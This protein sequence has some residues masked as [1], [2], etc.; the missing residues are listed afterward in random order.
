MD[1]AANELNSVSIVDIESL[2][3]AWTQTKFNCLIMHMNI[4]S[5]SRNSSEFFT[6]MAALPR[7]PD[8]LVLSETWFS[9]DT[10]DDMDG[11]AGF[12]VYR[13]DRR[14]GGISIYIASKYK[15]RKIDRWSFIDEH[16]EVCSVELVL[17]EEAITVV[18]IYRPPDRNVQMFTEDIRGILGEISHRECT[19]IT[20]DL[21]IDLI[22]TN[23]VELE[24]INMCQTLSFEPLVDI[25]T[26]ESANSVSRCLDH[27]WFNQLRET[28]SGT[29]MVDITDH[30]PVYTLFV[31]RTSDRRQIHK[32][33]R[34]HGY[35]ALEDLRV[36]MEVYANE[37]S[38][39]D[40]T[41]V[42]AVVERFNSDFIKIYN[43]CCPLR[44]KFLTENRYLKPW[45]GNDLIICINRKH[46]LFRL[47]KR[48]EVDFN[49]YNTYKNRVTG[50]IKRAKCKY[51]NDKFN[52]SHGDARETWKRINSLIKS[53]PTKKT[54]D[55]IEIE[56]RIVNKLDEIAESFSCHFRDVASNLERNIPLRDGSPLDYMGNRVQRSMFVTPS[57]DSETANVICKLKNKS[58][59]LHCIPTFIY[60]YLS[61]LISPIVS[62]LF[63]L[64][65]IQGVFPSSLKIARITPIFKAGNARLVENYRPISTLPVLSKIFEK[66]MLKRLLLFINCNDLLG[67]NQ[68]GFRKNNNTSDAILEF[69]DSVYDSLSKR[70]TLIA[71]FLD[72]SKAFDTIHHDI[73]LDKLEYI[74][75][76]GQVRDWFRSYIGD[77]FQ[78]VSIGK[79]NST[80]VGVQRG[81]PQG[82]VLGPVLFILYI[83]DMQNCCSS[84]K[85]LHFADD[86]SGF[87]SSNDPVDL[88]EKVSRDL[89]EI[90]EWVCRNRLFLNI[91][92]TS[93]MV[94]SDRPSLDLPPLMIGTSILERVTH[95]RFLGVIIDER[96]SFKQHTDKLCKKLSQT[97][98]M[99]NRVSNLIPTSAKLN[100]YFSLIFSRVSYAVVSWGGCSVVD[101]GRVERILSRARKLIDYDYSRVGTGVGRLLSFN[102][103]FKY[104]TAIKLFKTVKLDLHPHF[105]SIFESLRPAHH[106]QTRFSCQNKFNTPAYTKTKCQKSFLY[107]S[108]TVWNALPDRVK[109]CGELGEFKF[110]LKNFL[111]Q[112]QNDS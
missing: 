62:Q 26:H 11:Y 110:S 97:V 39:T 55:E 89:G 42:N 102:S 76:R 92:K 2:P 77:R 45:I 21:N 31:G 44:S 8:V 34:D 35:R 54:I 48:G 28:S 112:E 58:C 17:N 43:E 52:D 87:L 18:G 98:G 74:G 24:F 1:T 85:L 83:N 96:L 40:E 27:I 15:S 59:G 38:L 60:K 84:L 29:L 99:L 50:I 64:S 101:A 65:V 104:F 57:T 81:V 109:S 19:F 71:T 37:F 86:T 23:S 46:H 49:T 32:E 30:Y 73:L 41:N 56:G 10:V 72:F 4:R 25:P 75:I 80:R 100:I 108:V 70:R 3:H 5:Y 91:E 6:M 67:N 63:N 94:V 88:V 79:H 47:Y 22:E 7:K 107:K 90:S 16:C 82:S 111:I 51:Y 33:F 36:K 53:T 61:N 20:G 103:I 66:L 68:F 13:E 9:S 95:S 78:Y 12:H 105:S 93:Y 14:G 69:L 106:H